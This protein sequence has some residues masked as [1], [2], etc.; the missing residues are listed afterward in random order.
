MDAKS[1]QEFMDEI[2]MTYGDILPE[3]EYLL[4]H[5]WEWF[6]RR[7]KINAYVFSHK[8][9]LSKQMKALLT[10]VATAARMPGSEGGRYV[11]SH[12]RHALE[13]GA[14]PR[15]ILEAFECITFPVGG[16]A[17]MVGVKSLRDILEEEPHRKISEVEDSTFSTEQKAPITR[18]ALEKKQLEIHGYV[19]PEHE[20]IMDNDWDWTLLMHD[21][22]D[23][24]YTRR[25]GLADKFRSLAVVVALCARIP[26][27]EGEKYIRNHMGLAMKAGA[28]SDEILEALEC[29]YF[30]C[31]GPTLLVGVKCL[32]AVMEGGD[33]G[34]GA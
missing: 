9:S 6:R 14:T 33:A 34:R 29:A 19:L 21:F 28:T 23:H 8:S 18:S 32:R 4:E 24:T 26:G 3:H 20:F 25:G 5:D 1:K 7:H 15:E 2:R 12:V 31:G 16:I 13:L 17:F 22:Y 30:P 11:R 27:I 10:A